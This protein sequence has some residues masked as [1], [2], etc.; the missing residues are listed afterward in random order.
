MKSQDQKDIILVNFSEN[1]E[2]LC[3]LGPVT[4]GLTLRQSIL[5][6]PVILS[7]ILLYLVF[8]F[9]LSLIQWSQPFIKQPSNF[10]SES[11]YG[12]IYNFLNQDIQ[13]QPPG[14]HR[15]RRLGE[16]LQGRSKSKFNIILSYLIV[17][18]FL[19]QVS[20]IKTV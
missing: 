7:S 14:E 12:I 13:I 18:F 4:S 16:V 11:S 15:E 2:K 19:V 3:F 1:V 6:L 20:I 8:F 5:T 17:L 9:F 10:F